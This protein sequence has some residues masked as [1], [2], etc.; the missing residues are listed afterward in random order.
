ME[1]YFQRSREVKNIASLTK[2]VHIELI[3]SYSKT[4]KKAH[5]ISYDF[6]R[7]HPLSLATPDPACLGV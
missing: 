7:G 3:K 4:S 2:K 1:K 5:N 6:Y